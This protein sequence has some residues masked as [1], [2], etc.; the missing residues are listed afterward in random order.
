MERSI[1]AVAED[2]RLGV[3]SP[4]QARVAYGVIIGADGKVDMATIHYQSDSLSVYRNT[5]T[6]GVID[7]DSF[8]LPVSWAT[9]IHPYAVTR[10]DL[11]GDGKLDLVVSCR[12]TDS[13]I[14]NR[15]KHV[16]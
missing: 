8:A 13:V 10:G 15:K 16:I 12:Q 5:S 14:E 11:D 3:V 6:N 2:A 9:G 1:T 7:S 4:D